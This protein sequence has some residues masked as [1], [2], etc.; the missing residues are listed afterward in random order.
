[1]VGLEGETGIGERGKNIRDKKI[2]NNSLESLH[3][4]TKKITNI[5]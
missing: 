4:F 1:V 2:K 3:E 5:M